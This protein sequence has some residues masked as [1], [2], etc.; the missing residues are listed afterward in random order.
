MKSELKKGRER[1]D[2]AFDLSTSAAF[3]IT[4]L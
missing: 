4:G 1:N 3:T 2:Y